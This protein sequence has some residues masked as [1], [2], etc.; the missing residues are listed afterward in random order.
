MVDR[1]KLGRFLSYCGP[2]DY[3]PKEEENRMKSI[4]ITLNRVLWVTLLAQWHISVQR[5]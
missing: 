5:H 1:I 2:L 3:S 4:P